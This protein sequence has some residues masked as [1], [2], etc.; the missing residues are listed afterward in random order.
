MGSVIFSFTSPFNKHKFHAA[1]LLHTQ[2]R[3]KNEN[4]WPAVKCSV[5]ISS[6]AGRSVNVGTPLIPSFS[7]GFPEGNTSAQD[8]PF[9]VKMASLFLFWLYKMTC[10]GG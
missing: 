5:N 7:A 10:I 2:P 6:T 4:S 8:L 1:R 3:G 9:A